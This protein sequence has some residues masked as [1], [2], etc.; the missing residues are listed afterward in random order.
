MLNIKFQT[1]MTKTQNQFSRLFEFLSAREKIGALVF[2]V[3]VA[4]IL[5][6][7]I[8]FFGKSLQS[9][10]YHPYTLI[11]EGAYGYEG[12]RPFGA[13]N[14]D[15]SNATITEYPINK[16][17]GDIYKSGHL[18]LWNPYKGIGQPLPEQLGASAFFPFQVLE[19]ISPAKTWDFFMLGRLVIAAFFTFLFLRSLK[20]SKLGSLLGGLFYAFSGSFTW[21]INNEEMVNPAMMI[22]VL[23]WSVENLRQSGHF[24]Y[25]IFSALS[26]GLILMAGTPGVS[27]Y[28]LLLVLFYIVFRII[29]F[30]NHLAGNAKLS[31]FY[32]NK[33]RLTL[34]FVLVA[35]IGIS[36]AAPLILPFFDFLQ[37]AVVLRS[38]LGSFIVS[39]K[40]FGFIIFPGLSD[41]PISYRFGIQN[42]LWDDIGGYVGIIPIFLIILGGITVWRYRSEHKKD[43]HLKYFCFFAILG[44]LVLFKNYGFP[45]LTLIGKLPF[46]NTVWTPRWSSPIWTFS[47]AMAAVFAL[48][49]I[50]NNIGSFR[51][52][53]NAFFRRRPWS[54]LLIFIGISA[55]FACYIRNFLTRYFSFLLKFL[56]EQKD[57]ILT[58]A[59][60][61][62]LSV[63]F[64]YLVALIISVVFY[65]LATIII[66]A[67]VIYA[68]LY[69]ELKK[70]TVFD[71]NHCCFGELAL[72]SSRLS[73]GRIKDGSFCYCGAGHFLLCKEV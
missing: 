2:Y 6:S 51:E 66:L 14:V 63:V 70:T 48:E 26:L 58:I 34:L 39:P 55:F 21:F 52:R 72:D 37:S 71:F 36:L 7:P 13:F 33:I 43:E 59:D 67:L 68:L 42:G 19:D 69:G 53:I 5:Y 40:N 25:F 27:L 56:A 57:K 1:Q 20:I 50:R 38:E 16:L 65:Y 31:F 22:P 8:V 28:A 17:A 30:G 23:F 29:F 18:P 64:Y 62:L 54:C 35:L 47:F 3:L 49:I 12:R 60:P 41:I 4:S 44:A 24:K 32:Q 45:P 15:V 73:V 11:E 9:A 61:S 46:F 10:I